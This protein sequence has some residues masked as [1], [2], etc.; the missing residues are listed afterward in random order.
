MPSTADRTMTMAIRIRKMTTGWGTM[1]PTFSTP[2]RNL[3]IAVFGAAFAVDITAVLSTG[4]AAEDSP[5]GNTQIKWPLRL[6]LCSK[7]S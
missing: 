5:R 3:C 1:F 7:E 6:V 2:S 4:P